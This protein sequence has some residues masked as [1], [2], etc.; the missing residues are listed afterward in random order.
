MDKLH[1]FL[2]PF[3]YLFRPTFT[4]LNVATLFVPTP[5][6]IGREIKNGLTWTNIFSIYLINIF[7]SGLHSMVQITTITISLNMVKKLPIVRICLYWPKCYFG[8]SKHKKNRRP[9]WE[10]FTNPVPPKG[11][12]KA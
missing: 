2:I 11:I 5:S 8:I 7:L 9:T 4:T 10:I 6:K 1:F 3:I 12:P